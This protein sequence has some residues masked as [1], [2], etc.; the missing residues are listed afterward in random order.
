MNE[1]LKKFDLAFTRINKEYYLIKEDKNGEVL[2]HNTKLISYRKFFDY[3]QD[4]LTKLKKL[5]YTDL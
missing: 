5:K 2:Y 4:N 1:R 3:V